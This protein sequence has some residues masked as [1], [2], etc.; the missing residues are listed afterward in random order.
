MP[1]L[2]SIRAALAALVLAI[3]P[4][5][6]A[7]P[8]PPVPPPL[9]DAG[10]T[11]FTI[12]LRGLPVGSEQVATSRSGDGWTITST[13]RLGAPI[14]AVARRIVV[15]YTAE[16]KPLEFTLD[17]TVK[18]QPQ[19]VRTVI[20]GTI[21]RSDVVINGQPAPKSDNIDPAALLILPNSFFGPYEALALKLKTATPGSDIP[22]YGV[23]LLTFNVRVGESSSHQIQ[24]TSRLVSARRTHVTLMLPGAPIEADIWADDAGRMLRVSFLTSQL[25]VVR[26]DIAAVSSRSVVISRP[27]DEAVKIPSNGFSLAG[28]LSRPAQ[29]SAA[30]LPAVV[31]VGGSGPTDRDGIAYGIPILGQIADA[32]A[33]A[34][35]IVVR[36]DKRGIGQSGG[37]AES[38]TLADYADDL[39]AAVKMLADRKDV[40]PKR[41]AVAGHSEGG[42]VALMAAGKDKRIAGVALLAAPGFPGT[43]IV[44]A[45]QQRLLNHLKLTPEER[46][47]KVEAQKRIHEAVIT[48]KGLEQFSM[49]VRRTVENAEF[50]SLLMSDPAKLVPTVR[51]PLLIVQGDLDTQIEPPNADRLETLARARKNAPPVEMIK[52]PG[53]NHLLVPATTGEVDEYGTLR[54]AHVSPAVTGAITN[55]LQKTLSAAR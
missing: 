13:G 29:A 16:W 11:N 28:T 4:G 17:A 8:Q 51:Q 7:Q 9:P 54:D 30:R 32:L 1:S 38:A 39:R 5:V 37:R 22:V 55:W 20:E 2:H 48:G 47:A 31:L 40:D 26:E 45:Q 25:E 46:Q 52:V 18:G 44:L 34:G 24:T 36:Y 53:V 35:Y 6:S 23:P 49:D 41:I 14:D 50:Q 27:N 19:T 43:D 33:N 12:F 10:A 42:D 21:A 3:A 15:R